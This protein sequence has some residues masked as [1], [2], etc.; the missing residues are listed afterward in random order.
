MTSEFLEF[1]AAL[2]LVVELVRV[3]ALVLALVARQELVAR[4]AVQVLVGL[5]PAFE[6][7]LVQVRKRELELAHLELT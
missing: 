3:L 7:A 2:E 4:L 1:L 5:V 6:L